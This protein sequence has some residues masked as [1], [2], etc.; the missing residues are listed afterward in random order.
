MQTDSPAGLCLN[1]M[2]PD[3]SSP[4]G[5]CGWTPGAPASSPLYLVPGTVL[6][7]QYVVGRVL[8]H[9]GFGITY[10]GWDLHLAR[11]IAIKEYFPGGVGIRVSDS[12]NVFAYSP[13]F[14]AD[15][16]WGLD[17][18]LEEARV[19]ARFE[20]HPNIV[21]V[22][23]FFAANGTAYIILEY[24]DGATF[25]NYL[26]RAGGKVDWSIALR[27]LTPVMDALREVHRAGLLHRDVSPDNI[28]LTRSGL[29][30][31]IDFGA[32]RYS[33]GQHSKNLSVILKPGF[34]PPEQYQTRGNQ[35]P[36]TDV[37]ATACTFYRAITGEVPPPAPDR[38]AKVE[39]VPPTRLGVSMAPF[40]EQ[41]LLRALALDPAERFTG[42]EEF[43]RALLG[44]DVVKAPAPPPPVVVPP[45]PPV[46]VPDPV[47]VP[48]PV[49]PKLSF[50]EALAARLGLPSW[51]VAVAGG[52][53]LL[54]ALAVVIPKPHP[55]PE[56]DRSQKGEEKARPKPG[57]VD[58]L[59][60]TPDPV[61]KAARIVAFEFAPDQ[62][63]RG[64]STELRWSVEDAT[65]VALDGQTVNPSGRMT[66]QPDRNV[67]A[68]LTA[69]GAGG[70]ADRTAMVSVIDRPPPGPGPGSGPGA[71]PT[72]GP[73]TPEIV[74]FSATP[75]QVQAGQPVKLTWSVRRARVASISPTVGVLREPAGSVSIVPRRSTRYV[76]QVPGIAPSTVEVEVVPGPPPIPF[77]PP[78]GGGPSG[79]STGGGDALGRWE[80][81]HHHGF[82]VPSL[83]IDWGQT[84]N[85]HVGMRRN[86]DQCLGVLTL[87]GTRLRFDS[88]TSNDGFATELRNIEKV[89]V[90]R[91]RI[92][93]HASFQVKIRR[94]RNFN[95]VPRQP[96]EAVVGAIRGEQDRAKR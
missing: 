2:T 38:M 71:G 68:R 1:C 5:A 22:Q 9:G 73:D 89:E 30:K 70:A 21:W 72:A 41:A 55:D 65:R 88:R 87:D 24:L 3:A 96:V 64:Q 66:I 53:A 16:D 18:Y 44:E 84:R 45:P 8:G 91:T 35:G 83:S 90:N 42:M 48:V 40:A 10:L 4:C 85:G 29:V 12:P 59:K 80:V 56:P 95:F 76:L 23:N 37:Y 13:T 15:Y 39:L 28:Y 32:A 43:H 82:M 54:V 63:E 93:G 67:T 26:Q 86:D 31:V 75:L 47:P 46:P 77:G 57:P 81:Y 34:A 52:V 49:P 94:G 69:K 60:T 25:E 6:K 51:L 36:W 62:I 27:V 58:P 14:R 11:K 78:S 19:V 33:L 79:G 17:R 61:P 20:N 7:E 50:L 74:S 92:G